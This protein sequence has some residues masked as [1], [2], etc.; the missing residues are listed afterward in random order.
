MILKD[1][2]ISSDELFGKFELEGVVCYPSDNKT[3]C[4]SGTTEDDLV[5]LFSEYKDNEVEYDTKEFAVRKWNQIH[6]ILNICN[7]TDSLDL[8]IEPD[9]YTYPRIAYFSYENIQITHYLQNYTFISNQPDLLTLYKQKRFELRKAGEITTETIPL[10]T[11]K[12]LGRFSTL[13]NEKYFRIGK[14][15]GMDCLYLGDMEQ[16]IDCAKVF[17]ENESRDVEWRKETYFSIDYFNQLYRALGANE[18]VKVRFL[19]N[20]IIMSNNSNNCNKIGVLSGK[21]V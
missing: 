15:N 2:L 10:E 19:A 7:S 17:L 9:S 16:S 1:A 14:S 18:N 21:N 5:Y 20:K 11:V 13:L 6:H 4:I 8:R 3:C 12:M